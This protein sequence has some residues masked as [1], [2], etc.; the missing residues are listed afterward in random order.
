MARAAPACERCQRTGTW[1]RLWQRHLPLVQVA[2]VGRALQWVH[3][4]GRLVRAEHRAAPTAWA[5]RLRAALA[6]LVG[7]GVV[8]H[9]DRFPHR[10]T[11]GQVIADVM[12][13]RAWTGEVASPA[14]QHAV[15]VR[16][17]PRDPATLGKAD[18]RAGRQ[19]PAPGRWEVTP[20]S[21]RS[22]W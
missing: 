2:G 6:H 4:A 17:T 20:C 13:S 3:R 12:P 10:W 15:A 1:R 14:G 18:A 5:D 21:T 22:P 8:V 11:T 16:S 19:V 9:G 7:G